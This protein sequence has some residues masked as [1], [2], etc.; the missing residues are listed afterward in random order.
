MDFIFQIDITILRVLY[1][2]ITYFYTIN[3]LLKEKYFSEDCPY[4]AIENK[5]ALEIV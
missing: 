2:D 3:I 5:D 4:K 1:E